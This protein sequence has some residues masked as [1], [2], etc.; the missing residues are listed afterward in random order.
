MVSL[1]IWISGRGFSYKLYPS[2]CPGNIRKPF[3]NAFSKPHGI[4]LSSPSLNVLW[5]LFNLATGYLLF[6]ISHISSQDNFSL[7][8]FFSGIAGMS[9]RLSKRF[10]GKHKE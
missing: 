10:A 3:P 6:R 7:L 9:L 8:L 2:F 4:G 5:A 1:F